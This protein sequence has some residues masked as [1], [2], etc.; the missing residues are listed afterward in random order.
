M[1]LP[2]SSSA[3]NSSGQFLAVTNWFVNGVL[4][5]KLPDVVKVDVHKIFHHQI[6]ASL[7]EYGFPAIGSDAYTLHP[8][9]FGCYYPGNSIFTY[10]YSIGV[11]LQ[12]LSRQQK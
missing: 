4:S 9:A 6:S 1:L 5:E 7:L 2:G 10:Q 3:C 12:G 8:C 11:D